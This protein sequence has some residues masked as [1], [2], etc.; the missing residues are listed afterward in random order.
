MHALAWRN[1][2]GGKD[3][4]QSDDGFA[5]RSPLSVAASSGLEAHEGGAVARLPRRTHAPARWPTSSAIRSSTLRSWRA[6]ARR[7]AGHFLEA[8]IHLTAEG[9]HPG[10]IGYVEGWYVDPDGAGRGSGGGTD[11]G[12]R[13]WAADSRLPGDGLRSYADNTPDTRRTSTSAT[14]RSR[15]WPTSARISAGGSRR[16]TAIEPSREAATVNKDRLQHALTLA[17]DTHAVIVEPGALSASVNPGVTFPGAACNSW[18]TRT[19]W[20]QPAGAS[21]NS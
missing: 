8:S 6:P 11:P 9:C 21:P 10:R 3:P 2:P 16:P 17:T 13:T 20:P 7:S 1:R 12:G 18:P 14:R 4:V 15:C 19:R 5:C